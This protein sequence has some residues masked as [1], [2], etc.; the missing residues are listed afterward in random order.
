MY[1]PDPS[2]VRELTAYDDKLRIRWAR[3]SEKWLIER[4]VQVN[5]E[6]LANCLPPPD[7]AA[8][9]KRDLYDG[10]REGYVHVLTVPREMAYWHF[11]GPELVRADSWRQGGF[12][13][14]NDR[15]DK[16]AE[17]LERASDKR[18]DSY[19][20]EASKEAYERLQWL[21][22]NRFAVTNREPEYVDT[23]LGFSVRDRRGAASN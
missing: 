14:I 18:V 3:H 17:D 9:I 6:R 22:G 7:D 11:I 13:G 5:D 8:A 1:T 19:A 2:L 20:A 12:A 23:G 10:W 16:E 21:Q 15:L 4:K